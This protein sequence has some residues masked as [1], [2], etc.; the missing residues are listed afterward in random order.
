MILLKELLQ[1][2]KEYAD[3]KSKCFSKYN[4]KDLQQYQSIQAKIKEA[5]SIEEL[6]EIRNKLVNLGCKSMLNLG[7]LTHFFNYIKNN[8]KG[9]KVKELRLLQENHVINFLYTLS[10]TYKSSSMMNFKINMGT[11]FKFLD[12]HKK[13]NFDFTLKVALGKHK[14][15]PKFLPKE[16]FFNY[17]DYLK[18]LPCK[19]DFE[20]RSRLIALIVAYSGLRTIEI[21]NLKL[22]N[23]QSDDCNYI[24]SIRGKGNKERITLIKK[25]LIEPFLKEWLNSKTRNRKTTANE[26][27]KGAT[28]RYFL[29][30]TLKEIGLL[31]HFKGVGL[32]MLR[33]SFGSYIYGETKDLIL[34]QNAL[35]HSNLETTKI[36]IHTNS[37]YGRVVANLF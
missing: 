22:D 5:K 7:V 11:F 26:P 21:K 2:I 29:N 13:M 24:F 19:K 35:G 15:L 14:N 20:K 4:V 3:F 31:S 9:I 36:Y 32:H 30:K 1:A 27:F 17:I 6:N 8:H 16:Q 12:K 18:S 25:E 10:I 37:D 23:I 28:I 33:H 34:T